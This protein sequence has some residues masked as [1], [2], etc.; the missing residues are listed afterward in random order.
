ML[1]RLVAAGGKVV[2]TDRL[3]DDLWAGEPPPRALNA[4]QV[5]V[6]NL[7]RCLEPGRAPRTSA[8]VLVTS[9][10]GYALDLPHEA[11]DA[12]SFEHLFTAAVTERDADARARTLARALTLWNGTAYEEF[13][14]TGWAGPEVVRLEELRRSAV[15][16]WAAAMLD[17]SDA[18]AAVPELSVLLRI[19]PDR[20]ETAR[21]LA[22][23]HYRCGRQADAMSVLRSTRRYLV[24]ELG[25]DPGPALEATETTILTH[26]DSLMRSPIGVAPAPPPAVNRPGRPSS[27]VAPATCRHYSTKPAA[28]PP[29]VDASSGWEARRARER[30]HFAV[31]WPPNSRTRTGTSPGGAA[32]K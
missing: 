17:C 27:T 13:A 12:W 9:P 6:S 31:C 21:L 19:Q 4:L 15:E 20:E 16:R 7:R 18:A 30:A 5:H 14:D 32:P 8:R 1:A 23:A 26:G 22:L 10:P 3:I 25:L 24:D 11:V 29:P 2:S 28:P